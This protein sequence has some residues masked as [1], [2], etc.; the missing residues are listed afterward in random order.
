MFLL[1]AVPV[2]VKPTRGKLPEVVVAADAEES[3]P[4]K[5]IGVTTPLP[6]ALNLKLSVHDWAWI[7][8]PDTTNKKT[9]TTKDFFTYFPL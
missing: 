9:H 2:T 1:G 6:Q 5:A 3:S 4:E 8:R 7:E